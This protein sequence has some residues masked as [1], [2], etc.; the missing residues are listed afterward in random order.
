MVIELTGSKSKITYHPK[1]PDD[2]RQRK[3][4]IFPWRKSYRVGAEDPLKKGLKPTIE[5]FRN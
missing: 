5:Y 4:P 2:P 3:A 1:P